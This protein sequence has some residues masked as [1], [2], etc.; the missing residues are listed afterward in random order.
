MTDES[1][2]EPNADEPAVPP[3][4]DVLKDGAGEAAVDEP[5][6][7]DPAEAEPAADEPDEPHPDEATA[8]VAAAAQPALPDTKHWYIVKVQS[9]REE[10]IKGGSRSKDWRSS[11][12][13]SRSRWNVS[14]SSATAN[15]WSERGRSFPAT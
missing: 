9:G 8:E 6:P 10:S 7:P 13:G 11:S 15:G 5:A 4:D 12:A 1:H 2:S 14:P 3:A